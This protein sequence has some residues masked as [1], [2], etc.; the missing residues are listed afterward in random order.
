MVHYHKRG[1][2]C[3]DLLAAFSI[4]FFL[5]FST[6]RAEIGLRI[7]EPRFFLAPIVSPPQQMDFSISTP[8][9]M[10]PVQ[11]PR[12]FIHKTTIDSS[13]SYVIIEQQTDDYNILPPRYLPFEEYI[14]KKSQLELQANWKEYI[15]NMNIRKEGVTRKSTGLKIETPRIKSKTF[16]RVFGGETLSLNVTGNITIDGSMRNEKRSQVKTATTR[17]PNT[18]FQMKQTQRFKVEGKIGENVSVLVDQDSERPFEFENAIKLIYSSD[19]DGILQSF[20]AGNVALTLPSTRFVTFSAQ[21]SGLFGFKSKFK[22]GGL[23][24]TAIASMEKGEKKKLSLKGGKEDQKYIIHDYEYKK[25]TYFFLGSSYREMYPK[26]DGQGNHFFYEDSVITD[27]LV[28]KSDVNYENKMGSIL[29]WA[30]LDPAHPDSSQNTDESYKGYFLRLEPSEYYFNAELGFIALNQSLQTSEVLAVAYW[31]AK[32]KVVGDTTN[33]IFKII[34]PRNPDPKY[35]ATWSLE[36]KNVYSLGGR[37]IQR[38]GFDLKLY[39]KPPSG[40]PQESIE[41]DGQAKGYLEIFGLDNINEAGDAEPDN[42]IDI[43]PNIL[44]LSRGELIFPNLRPFD[45]DTTI[46][47]LKYPFPDEMND[48]RVSAIYDTTS[49][50]YIN[51]ESKFYMEANSSRRSPNYSLG[52]NVIEGSEEVILNGRTLKKDQDYIIDY[53]SGQLTLLT[54]D[55][56][57]PNASLDI[58]YESQ[59][60]FSID[61]KTLMGARAEY[62][63]FDE[64]NNRS[65]IG[66]TLLYLNQKTIEQRV[67]VGKGPMRNLVWDVNTALQYE[68][69]FLTPALDKLPLLNVNQPSSITF[70]GE[71]AQIIPNP[72]TLNNESTGDF[73]GVAYLD[74]FEGA[75]RETPLGITYSGWGPCSPPTTLENAVASLAQR[76]HLIWYNPYGQVAIKEI[77]PDREVTTNYGGSTRTHVLNL[78]FTPNPDA[79]PITSSWGGIQRWLSSGYADQTDS[80]YLEVWVKGDAGRLNVDMGRISED[81]IPNK[82]LN[83]EDKRRGGI[84]NNLLDDDEDTGLDG[85]FGS[86]PP[87]LFYPHEEAHVSVSNGKVYGTPYDFWDIDG[88]STKSEN[89]PWSYD[90]WSYK[91]ASGNYDHINGTENNRNASTLISPD[92]EDLDGSGDVDL[93]NDY[94]EFSFSL[95]KTSLDT[96]YI[97][98][99]KGNPYGWRLYRIPLNE[100]TRIIGSPDWSHIK[101]VRVW[102]D[103]VMQKTE[104]SIAEINL[105]GNEWK[106]RGVALDDTSTYDLSNDSTMTIAVINTHD[107]PEYVAPPGVEG[108]I[109]PI[110]RIRSKEQSLVIRLD[111]LEPGTAAKAQKQFYQP[112]NLINYKE[113]KMFVHGGNAYNALPTDTTIEFFLQWGS[114]MNNYYEVQLPV[115][116][117]WD[118]HNNI[119]IAFE[120]LSR[121][122]IQMSSTNRDTIEELQ[123]NGHTIRVIGSPSLTNVRQLTIGIKNKG[124]TPFSGEIWIDELRLSNVRKDK[125]MAMRAR[126]DIRLS[127]FITLVGEYNRKDADFHTINERFGTGNNSVGGQINMS[128]QLHKLLPSNWGLSIPI[129]ANYS[130]TNDTPKFL[131]GSDI[132]VNRSTV[133]DDSLWE[134]IKSINEQKGASL[135]IS[136]QTKSRNFWIRYL[137]DPIRTSFSYSQNDLSNSQTKYSKSIG[138]HGSLSYGLNFGNQFYWLPL[139]WVGRKGLLGKL[140]KTKFYYMPSNI[141]LKFDGSDNNKDSETRSGIPSNVETSTYSRSFSTGYTMFQ[142]LSFDYSR[143]ISSDMRYARWADVFSTFDPGEKT[144]INQ[145]VGY[146]FNPSIFSW[147]THTLKYNANYRWNNNLQMKNKGTGQSASIATSFSVTGNLNPQNFVKSFKKKSTSRSPRRIRKPTPSQQKE[148]KEPK[149]ENDHQGIPL[150]AIFSRFGKLLDMIDPISISISRNNSAANYGILGTPSFGYQIGATM[151]PG[152]EISDNL[153]SDRNST[154]QDKRFSMR[155]GLKLS[156]KISIKFDYDYSDSKS[157]LTQTTGTV[158]KSA[159]LIKDKAVPFPNWSVQWRGLEG[160]PLLKQFTKS[161]SLTHTFSGKMTQTWNDNRNNKTRETINKS[162]NPLVGLSFSFKNGMSAN[163]QY[164]T[165]ED[166]TTQLSYGKG[167]TK[168]P[169]SSLTIS[170]NYSKSGGF[171]LPFFG[172]KKL[173]NNIDFTLSFTRSKNSMFQSQDASDS[174]QEMSNTENWSLQPKI[175]Y[176]FTQ[177]VRGS[178]YFEFGERKDIKMG[179]T[180]ITAFGVNANISLAG[181]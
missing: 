99:G 110:Q 181:G 17:A 157:H 91:S 31:P 115:F 175:S 119:E 128:I 158:S 81:A 137:I 148:Q 12:S 136:K 130:K 76:G 166:L 22:I 38:E 111:N 71:L 168:T 69:K 7:P 165:G 24:I 118:K 56:T 116:P 132:L 177:T 28:Y 66:A 124:T 156:S 89:E 25:N 47:D 170:A 40:D 3:V 34:K 141:N 134:A 125:G 113:M 85:M 58:N 9:S 67:R 77:W 60:L 161:V 29:G 160:L 144:S 68:P 70:E 106:L 23:D 151:D 11:F 87:E 93:S 73:D 131:P 18:N 53:F 48:K 163:V 153:T 105:A 61:K 86:D 88:D 142:T 21:N 172:G 139:K 6:A 36:W 154:K 32:G 173:E 84:R 126:A 59:Q 39:Y 169:S 98:G 133:T 54:E 65:F 75:K 150:S 72:N 146:T 14:S 92:R 26:L 83:T 140:A 174:F 5:Q 180:K 35:K 162:F 8:F 82:K 90:N 30:V 57:D 147:L 62:T 97:G 167:K 79:A 100:P 20:E 95:D 102:V 78:E 1:S 51:G 152:V 179:S 10:M 4:F 121:L 41:V 127:D 178:M 13:G 42:V 159:L 122:K 19:E 64:G 55:A 145:Q 109:D 107:N 33:A 37:D 114:D 103:S 129:T 2:K 16:K 123:S 96:A 143:S 80:R 108:V 43:D 94:F 149:K 45:P 101:Y 50:S 52:I 104:I 117:G 15:R 155:S 176:T 63:L 74:D 49:T 46:T 44:N 112:E 171:K 120:T 138:Y 164:S 27:L 135:S